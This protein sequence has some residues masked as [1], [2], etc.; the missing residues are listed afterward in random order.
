VYSWCMAR[1][2]VDIDEKACAAVMRRY[3]LVTKRDA[4]NFALR[5]LAAEPL[6]LD[7]ARALRGSGW[8]GDLDEMRTSR[9]VE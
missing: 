7:E 8:D 6:S 4:V 5:H 9:V 2:N 1:T 3:G